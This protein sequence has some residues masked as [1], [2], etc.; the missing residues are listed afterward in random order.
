MS[1]ELDRRTVLRGTVA[2][3]GAAAAAALTGTA[4]DA[5][6][7]RF[8]ADLV[9]RGGRVLVLD[10]RFRTAEALAVRG[11]RVVAVGRD[12]DVCGLI[13]RNT[14]VLDVGGG[15]VLPGIN[16]SHVH[17]NAVGL[18]TPPFTYDVDTATIDE[19][20]A[21]VG[22]AVAAAP[23]PDSWIRGQGWNDNRLPRPPRR[24]DLDPVTGDHP[25]ILTDFSGHAVA[26]NSV[27]LR[28]AGIT[29]DTAP[30][31]AV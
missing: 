6:P 24:T 14:R 26:V 12:R 17:L 3:A 13:G 16:D 30:R 29:R 7:G 22:A 2:A 9:I 18:N 10:Q 25:V 11:G 15:T 8:G 19:L 27:A 31:P 28:L 23:S 21:A 5:S 1:H 20:V 4:A